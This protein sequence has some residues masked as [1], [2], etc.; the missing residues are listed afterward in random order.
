MRVAEQL[1]KIITSAGE[2]NGRPSRARR[3]RAARP[4]AGEG[5]A[6][7]RPRPRAPAPS[8][9]AARAPRGRWRSDTSDTASSNGAQRHAVM[10]S[11][12]CGQV[13][14]RVGPHEEEVADLVD[15]P[16][17]EA[18]V[19]VDG[20]DLALDRRA[21][22]ARSP[23][24]PRARR[25]PAGPRPARGA[26][27]GTPSSGSCHGSAG[28]SAATARARPPRAEDDPARRDL[29][30]RARPRRHGRALR[31]PA[32]VV[33]TSSSSSGDRTTRNSSVNPPSISARPSMN[34]RTIGSVVS[35]ISSIVPSHR[36]RPS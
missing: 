14:V 21:R 36:T 1:V 32:A 25:R 11:S 10:P 34:W 15:Q 5:S 35:R 17:A 29:L 6:G 31:L 18:E 7:R 23:R 30:A 16:A 22:R 27:S 2:H 28:T 24:S 19:P 8:L 3:R 13:A 20:L 12:R 26:P 33:P 4:A 9:G